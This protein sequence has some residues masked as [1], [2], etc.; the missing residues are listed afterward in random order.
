MFSAHGSNF[1]SVVDKADV[2]F[3]RPVAFADV[4]F[5][6]SLQE[7]SPGVCPQTVPHSHSDFMIFVVVSLTEDEGEAGKDLNTA[8]LIETN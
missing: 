4:N 2:S 6:K 7:F 8:T 1:V 3:S 5:S